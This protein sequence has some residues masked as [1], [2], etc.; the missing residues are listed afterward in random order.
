MLSAKQW[1]ID[2]YVYRTGRL[3]S[4]SLL[5]YVVVVHYITTH[6]SVVK[7]WSFWFKSLTSNK[8][9]LTVAHTTY[10]QQIERRSSN[11]ERNSFFLTPC[12]KTSKLDASWRM[13][14]SPDWHWPRRCLLASS[15]SGM[16]EEERG[17]R[18]TFFF[19]LQFEKKRFQKSFSF[20]SPR[21][22][23]LP[24]PLTALILRVEENISA[25]TRLSPCSSGRS[26]LP[27]ST[28]VHAS[29]FCPILPPPPR[30]GLGQV[31]HSSHFPLCT[32]Q[33]RFLNT[34]VCTT[35]RRRWRKGRGR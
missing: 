32:V 30:G 15:T 19:R 24:P 27:S 13:R 29:F 2:T 6:I 11:S 22:R 16:E 17:G 28:L 1:N 5:L 18:Q 34:I 25:R 7:K 23:L 8:F 10:S 3:T 14:N 4:T 31:S 21:H 26:P 12:K 33:R 9:A 35:R 20:F